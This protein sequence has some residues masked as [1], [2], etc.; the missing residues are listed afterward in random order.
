MTVARIEGGL[1]LESLD[2]RIVVP[3]APT[4]GIERRLL[5]RSPMDAI[6]LTQQVSAG[7]GV[8]HALAAARAWEAAGQIPVSPNGE[9]LREL[10]NL[11]AFL[12]DHVRQFYFETL[13]DYLPLAVLA[14]YRGAD[15]ELV[16]AAQG[17]AA[18]LRQSRASAAR[19][20]AFPETARRRLA[21]STARAGRALAL[22]QR[23]LGRLGGKFPIVMSIVPG[24]LSAAFDEAAI[25]EI[26]GEL[27]EVE[28][29]LTETVLEDALSVLEHHP[30]LAEL[31]RGPDN[32]LSVGAGAKLNQQSNELMPAGLLVGRRLQALRLNV[33]ESIR[34]AFYRVPPQRGETRIVLE[35]EPIK[36]AAYSW[37]KAPRVGEAAVETGPLARL[38]VIQLSG[39][40]G[41]S[42][43]IAEL[44][45]E[46][47]DAPLHQA[48]TV[49]G[50]L[51]AR[52][53]ELDLAFRRCR[54]ILRGYEPGQPP[55]DDSRDPFDITG[56][57]VGMIEAP[58]GAVRHRCVLEDGRITYYDIVAPSTWNGSPQDEQ[59]IAGPLEVA[60]S[61][62]PWNPNADS[63]ALALARIVHS[64]AFSTADAVH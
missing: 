50:R 55:I 49:A 56:D 22:I 26:D 35:P 54:E 4:R 1:R 2:G 33:T 52:A 7:N 29:F 31:G 10:L 8:A 39:A 37:I 24:G 41:R 25:L 43:G 47:V 5:G 51:L 44:V 42:A 21:E 34:R 17:I 32:F 11:L 53:G 27:S 36:A 23:A 3:G 61:R 6:Y 59:G 40:H 28:H 19:E 15:A 64:F 57:G 58:A 16:R 20:T 14:D 30:E 13:P 38:A 46:Q 18:R 62:R 45:A 12:H 48:N 63:D 9:L 60:C